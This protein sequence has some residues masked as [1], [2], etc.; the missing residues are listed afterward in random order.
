MLP[1]FL[2]RKILSEVNFPERTI[3]A[4]IIGGIAWEFRLCQAHRTTSLAG[5]GLAVHGLLQHG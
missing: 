1:A 2:L 5:A 3:G 4:E